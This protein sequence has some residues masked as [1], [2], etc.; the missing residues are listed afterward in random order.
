LSVAIGALLPLADEAVNRADRR[1]V[2][3]DPWPRTSLFVG[4]DRRHR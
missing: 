1:V 2:Q 4:W 3:R